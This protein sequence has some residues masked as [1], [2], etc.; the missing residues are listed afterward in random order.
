MKCFYWSSKWHVSA[1]DWIPDLFL[2]RPK[3]WRC[4]LEQFQV[5]HG[6][7]PAEDDDQL[8][9]RLQRLV[10]ASHAPAGTTGLHISA[11]A[12]VLPLVATLPQMHFFTSEGILSSYINPPSAL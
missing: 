6:E 10:P 3:V 12:G 8:G 5:Q 7:L 9:P 4:L 2:V 11:G 1:A